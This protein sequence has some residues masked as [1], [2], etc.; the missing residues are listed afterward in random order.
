MRS[1]NPLHEDAGGRA[2]MKTPGFT[3]WLC[4]AV[5]ACYCIFMSNA[6]MATVSNL[7][8]SANTSLVAF[9]QAA[10]VVINWSML[11]SILP[12]TSDT[13]F[14]DFGEF[15]G[16]ALLG[17]SSV[18]LAQGIVATSQSPVPVTF[19]EVLQIPSSII[20][21]ANKNGSVS[22]VY[23]RIF[24]DSSGSAVASVTLNVGSSSSGLLNLSRVQLRFDNEKIV[25][26]AGK[27]EKLT[28]IA[29]VS[30]TGTGLLDAE[31]QVADP[32]S[33]FGEPVFVP[34][35]QVRQYLGAGRT[36][37]LQS[38]VLPTS[39]SGA[40]LVKLVVNQPAVSFGLP[41]LTYHVNTG[42]S[43][44]TSQ[45]PGTSL[46]LQAPGPRAFLSP[47]TEFRWQAVEGAR[48]YQLELHDDMREQEERIPATLEKIDL[49]TEPSSPE[50]RPVTGMRMPAGRTS[51]SLSVVS[52][53][54]LQA[55]RNYLWR[56]IAIGSD[57]AVL[58]TSPLQEIYVP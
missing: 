44:A 7:T 36:A 54:Y 57:G 35:R 48:A 23:Q 56:V 6:A 3:R 10:S 12:G 18:R 53:Q 1:R 8:A 22:I 52:R 42:I 17:T 2:G 9:G 49:Q 30:Y 32:A 37:I 34:L 19:R 21:Q 20:Y 5:I 41:A 50:G 46:R 33:T 15:Y 29:E 26:I 40:H 14:S 38:P 51:A 28:A 13:V 45:A 47:V 27:D 55:G 31:W 25:H 16:P 11:S 39:L 4:R 43:T 24:S 58:A